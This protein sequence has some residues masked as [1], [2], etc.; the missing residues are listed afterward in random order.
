M[1]LCQLSPCRCWAQRNSVPGPGRHRGARIRPGSALA[2][3]WGQDGGWGCRA[4]PC[5][6]LESHVGARWMLGHQR[7]GAFV[8]CG[9]CLKNNNKI[10]SLRAIFHLESR[11]IDGFVPWMAQGSSGSPRIDVC[12][13][14]PASQRAD[15]IVSPISASPQKG[16]TG[17]FGQREQ[18]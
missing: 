5:K 10:I 6:A 9:Q 1:R 16:Y 14:L 8:G 2:L 11:L 18:G 13:A 7:Q 12:S 17:H 4:G 15:S 3:H